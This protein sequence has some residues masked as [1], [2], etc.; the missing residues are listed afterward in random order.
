MPCE[1]WIVAGQPCFV[2]TFEEYKIR[3]GGKDFRFEMH[4]YCGPTMIGKRGNPI[5]FPPQNSPFW[6]ALH[7]WLKQGKRV[8]AQGWC[9]FKW[10]M[11]PVHIIKHMGGRH[12]KVLA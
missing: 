4:D 11:Q 5:A 6:E 1:K 2:M 8:D 3:A 7:W 9:L 10:E 12:Y